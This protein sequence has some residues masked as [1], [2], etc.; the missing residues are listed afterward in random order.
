MYMFAFSVFNLTLEL[1]LRRLVVKAIYSCWITRNS[2]RR[3]RNSRRRTS[4]SRW[5]TRNEGYRRR[6]HKKKNPVLKALPIPYHPFCVD[7]VEN[8]GRPRSRLSL[9]VK[10][11]SF[12]DGR[13]PSS[14]GRLSCAVVW[15]GLGG[16]WA[17]GAFDF[18]CF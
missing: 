15:L 18:C 12:S 17:F 5:R 13:R 10:D 11:A 8:P 6:N 2:R 3:T 7:Q 16:I 4:N 9:W 14:A 1:L